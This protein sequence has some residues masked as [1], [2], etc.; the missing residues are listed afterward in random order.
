MRQRQA[1][2]KEWLWI[3][4][5]KD[6]SGELW[7]KEAGV[8]T[9]YCLIQFG[10]SK[11]EKRAKAWKHYRLETSLAGLGCGRKE[12][13]ES[14]CSSSPSSFS[15]CSVKPF[16]VLE[17]GKKKRGKTSQH[18]PRWVCSRVTNPQ[19]RKQ[20]VYLSEEREKEKRVNVLKRESAHVLSKDCFYSR[21]G[22]G[23]I[24]VR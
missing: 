10:V 22:G 4:V 24:A 1:R 2:D 7:G 15:Y 11:M 17:Q 8:E 13:F 9:R 19:A 5:C 3:N 6:K 12:V 20:R 14:A 23:N 21:D 16:K 18:F